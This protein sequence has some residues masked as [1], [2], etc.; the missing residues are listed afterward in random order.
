[1]TSGEF[2]TIRYSS[3]V[4]NRDER[5]RRE[6]RGID[7]L[8]RSISK[9]GL[10]HPLVVTRDHVLV[11][12]ERRYTALG[13]LGHTHVP[14]QY[15]DELEPTALHILELEENI[16]REDIAWQDWARAVDR[17]FEM[18]KAQDPQYN[19]TKCANELNMSQSKLSQAFLVAK[20]LKGGNKRVES[21]DLYSTA[22]NVARRETDRRNTS[23]VAIHMDGKTAEELKSVREAPL[24]NVAFETWLETYSGPRFNLIH[25]D[26]PYG[27]GMHDSDQGAASKFGEYH[28]DEDV[29]WTCLSTLQSAMERVVED[30]AHLMFWFS[31][32]YYHETIQ[33][34]EAM[35]WR[36]NSH[37]L[38][39]HKS[40]NVGILSDPRRG[41]RRVYETCLFAARGDRFV[42]RPVSNVFQAPGGNKEIHMN[43]K[44][45]SMLKYFMGMFCDEYSTVLDPTAG[46]ANA[47]KAAES[48]GSTRVLGLERDTEFFTRAREA[49]YPKGDEDDE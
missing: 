40:D 28:D 17:Y 6:L 23:N 21:Q 31:M 13:Q 38:V 22:V 30:S 15:T 29:Y 37:P 3:I 33:R 39:W 16:K 20:E 44:P 32:E 9:V 49:Y 19:G 48:L 18:R 12:G 35:G 4:V 42:V 43:E 45:V 11:A 27:I 25:C 24:L 36:V 8:A 34:L 26:F 7:D 2:T 14:V 41:P 10:I 1:V 47:L 46:S 5:Q